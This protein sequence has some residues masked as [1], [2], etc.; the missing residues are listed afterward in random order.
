LKAEVV[1][2]L[3]YRLRWLFLDK[4]CL[5]LSLIFKFLLLFYISLY[6]HILCLFFTIYF[7]RFI[8]I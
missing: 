3:Q 1:T 2:E 6:F 5:L 7:S 8:R 4:A